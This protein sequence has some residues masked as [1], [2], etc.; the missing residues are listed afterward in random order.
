LLILST[1]ADG[2]PAFTGDVN[3]LPIAKPKSSGP[4]GPAAAK[5]VVTAP[6]LMV[7]LPGGKNPVS[8]LH[9]LYPAEALAVDDMAPETPGIFVSRV[10]IEERDFEV[11]DE[12]AVFVDDVDESV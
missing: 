8:L 6:N 2:T 9:E 7:E 1:C 3:S 5:P 4:A 11:S 10:R 12:L